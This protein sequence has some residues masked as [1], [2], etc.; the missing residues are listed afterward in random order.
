MLRAEAKI[1]ADK[2]TVAGAF[3]TAIPSNYVSG[4]GT[5]HVTAIFHELARRRKCKNFLSVFQGIGLLYCRLR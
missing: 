1:T 4:V 5:D 2:I 3:I